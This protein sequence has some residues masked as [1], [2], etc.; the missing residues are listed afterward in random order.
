[1]YVAS[2]LFT[3]SKCARLLPGFRRGRHDERK[4]PEYIY[5]PHLTW[6]K[7]KSSDAGKTLL[8]VHKMLGGFLFTSFFKLH[9]IKI[10]YSF[11][12]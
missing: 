9:F 4:T 1:M 7:R 12:V 3:G 5:I 6:R 10:L 2:T 8:Y 11:S